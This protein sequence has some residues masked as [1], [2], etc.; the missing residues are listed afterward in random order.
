MKLLLMLAVVCGLGLLSSENCCAAIY[1]YVDNEGIINFADDLQSVPEQYRATAKIVSGEAVEK[2]PAVSSRQ[3]QPRMKAGTAAPEPE[4]AAAPV[5]QD[6]KQKSADASRA[7][8]FFG[9]KAVTSVMVVVSAVFAFIILGVFH[10]DHKKVVAVVRIT[11]LW[12]TAVYLIYAHAGDVVRVFSAVGNRVDSV[13]RKSEEKGRKAAK[14]VK[15]LNSLAEEAGQAPSGPAEDGT[16][17]E[18]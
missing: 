15:A 9:R 1:K 18:K 4:P 8:G 6:E 7:A 16:E 5:V 3:G 12:G 17:N 13:Q 14:A 11:V 10:T 2:L